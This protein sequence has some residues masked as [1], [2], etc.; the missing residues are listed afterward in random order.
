MN[1]PEKSGLG[2]DEIPDELDEGTREVS[3]LHPTETPQQSSDGKK[4]KEKQS[5][6]RN[7]LS[8]LGISMGGKSEKKKSK[9]KSKCDVSQQ[10][11]DKDASTK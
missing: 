8:V 11:K 2:K 6:L 5:M 3:S 1:A 4:P 7:P 9:S 10:K